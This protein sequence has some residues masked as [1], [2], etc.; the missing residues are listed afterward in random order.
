[1]TDEQILLLVAKAMTSGVKQEGAT[2]QLPETMVI[3]FAK[4]VEK[5]VRS[6]ITEDIEDYVWDMDPDYKSFAHELLD[7]VVNR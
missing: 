3:E 1:M 7:E 6:D 5:Q 2:F 4:L